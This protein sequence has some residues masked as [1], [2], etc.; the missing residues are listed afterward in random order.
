ML[1]FTIESNYQSSSVLYESEN[2]EGEEEFNDN[3]STTSLLTDGVR[4]QPDKTLDM[5]DA[6]TNF[7]TFMTLKI[8]DCTWVVLESENAKNVVLLKL[9]E[10]FE[11]YQNGLYFKKDLVIKINP[12]VLF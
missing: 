11:P 2:E 5:N 7:D 3:Q 10:G 6:Y 1:P 8:P 12:C 9:H 4:V